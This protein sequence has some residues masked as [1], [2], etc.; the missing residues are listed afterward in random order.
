MQ[1]VC[2]SI[3]LY[4]YDVCLR[5]QHIELEMTTAHKRDRVGGEWR[6]KQAHAHDQRP[7]LN[8][9]IISFPSRTGHEMD[10]RMRW[11][12][13]GLRRKLINDHTPHSPLYSWIQRN[14][15]IILI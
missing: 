10:G 5:S 15:I 7:P 1:C 14:I 8:Y 13:K 4:A 9:I 3:S 6:W 2:V 12:G 11:Q